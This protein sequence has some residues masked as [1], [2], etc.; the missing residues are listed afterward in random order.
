MS[1]QYVMSKRGGASDCGQAGLP[2]IKL[3]LLE[4]L[5]A[6]FDLLLLAGLS[7]WLLPCLTGLSAGRTKPW[8][9][10]LGCLANPAA[11]CLK[12]PLPEGDIL[13]DL[14][15]VTWQGTKDLSLCQW[16]GKAQSIAGVEHQS[17][18]DGIYV[19]HDKS[20]RLH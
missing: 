15:L 2:C 20:T 8:L 14:V 16:S 19:N 7:S 1:D 10:L 6:L 9:L 4:V 13:S 5:P 11:A 18:L 12:L 3:V 17:R